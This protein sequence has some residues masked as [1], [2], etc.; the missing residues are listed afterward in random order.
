MNDQDL[1]AKI[2]A[3]LFALG[4][5]LSRDELAQKLQIKKDEL[6]G[7]I[8]ALRQNK[9]G[10]ITL[11]DDGRQ[12]EL[13]TAPAAAELIEKIRKEEYAR[14]IGRAGLEVIDAEGRARDADTAVGGGE[15][16]LRRA[17]LELLTALGRFP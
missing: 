12:L 16:T 11:V 1:A 2:E 6:E 5:P 13:R 7:D 3:L 17:R 10:G 9:T 15:D 8:A 4:R 14:D